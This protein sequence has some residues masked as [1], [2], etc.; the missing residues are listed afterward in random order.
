MSEAALDLFA[1]AAKARR[2]DPETS[3]AA[4]KGVNVKAME[5]GV[6]G[7]LIAHGPSTSTEVAGYLNLGIQT[8][9]PRFRPLTRKGLIED[10]GDRRDRSIVWRMVSESRS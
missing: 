6:I 8:V 2:S 1:F 3:H 4:A 7:A 5:A 10:S 9:S